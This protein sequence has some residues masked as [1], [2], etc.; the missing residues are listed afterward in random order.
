MYLF[1]S[2]HLNR[3]KNWNINKGKFM[4]SIRRKQSHEIIMNHARKDSIIDIDN[5]SAS[6][7]T[8]EN[9]N[10]ALK[11][12][13]TETNYSEI[14]ELEDT[15]EEENSFH[16]LEETE[17]TLSDQECED[18][19]SNLNDLTDEKLL[20]SASTHLPTNRP[21]SSAYLRKEL[22]RKTLMETKILSGNCDILFHY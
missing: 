2:L 1:F 9:R 11:S 12:T 4:M 6:I 21:K 14:N 17:T 15:S 7:R 16:Q 20:S 10:Y 13:I 5:L 22:L 3:N 19:H 18:G 8:R